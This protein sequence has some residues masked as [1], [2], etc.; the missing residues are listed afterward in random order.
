MRAVTC[1]QAQLA[2][3]DVPELVPEAGQVVLEVLR[4]GI[5]GS[6]LHAR[7]HCDELAGVMLEMGYDGFMRSDQQIV[8]GHEFCGEVAAYGPG[9]RRTVPTGTPVVAMP[10]LRGGGQVHATGLS[11]SAPGA[12]AEQLLVEAV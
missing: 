7:H 5:C 9:C 12:Y 4:C 6:D 3:A 10:L 11:A 8:F 1:T 2:V